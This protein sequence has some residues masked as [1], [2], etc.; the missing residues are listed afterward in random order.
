[1]QCPGR[2]KISWSRSHP[3]KLPSLFALTKVAAMENEMGEPFYLTRD[4]RNRNDVAVINLVSDDDDD[5]DDDD[6][7]PIHLTRDTR[8][9]EYD[10]DDDDDNDDDADTVILEE[11]DLIGRLEDAD[12]YNC[13]YS[14]SK[15]TRRGR[16]CRDPMWTQNS[17]FF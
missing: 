8:E 14:P 1:M 3:E 17:M 10:D 5:D 7:E 13:C 4:T 11:E 12:L 16:I 2:S 9:Q 6:D 15:I